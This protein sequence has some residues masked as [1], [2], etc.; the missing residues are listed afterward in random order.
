MRALLGVIALAMSACEAAPPAR[1]V[2]MIVVAAPTVAAPERSEEPPR[3]VVRHVPVKPAEP[4]PIDETL[5]PLTD[6][7][8]NCAPGDPLCTCL[9]D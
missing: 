5:P 7:A 3:S 6:G 1:D 8:C 9:N 4:P 2:T